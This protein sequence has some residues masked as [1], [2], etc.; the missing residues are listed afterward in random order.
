MIGIACFIVSQNVVDLRWFLYLAALQAFCVAVAEYLSARETAEYH[1]SNW[2]YAAAV[3]AALSCAVLMIFHK[4]TGHLLSW[5]LYSYLW[6]FGLDLFVLSCHMLFEELHAS[7]V[8][9]VDVVSLSGAA[10]KG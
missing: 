5:L 10:R 8:A 9:K 1:N 6:C 2:C 3:I 4:A 7:G